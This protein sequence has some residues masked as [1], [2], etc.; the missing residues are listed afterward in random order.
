[1]RLEKFYILGSVAYDH[2]S[3]EMNRH[4]YIPGTTVTTTSGES[5]TIQ[6]FKEYLTGEFNSYSFSGYFETGYRNMIDPFELTP[7]VGV[8]FGLLRTE[9]FTETNQGEASTI[10]LTYKSH[11]IYSVPT[12]LGMQL[13]VKSKL[14]SDVIFSGWARVAWRHEFERERSTESAFI[15]APEVSF[16]IQGAQPPEDALR[17][18]IGVDLAI[19]RNWSIFGTYD[20]DYAGRDHSYS[21]LGGINLSW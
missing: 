16:E 6:G 17:G 10:G 4:A 20:Y 14:A 11:S 2:F 18:T 12:M 8:Q 7:F 9:G 1:M 19:G 13:K 5:D 15:S 3:N 21:G